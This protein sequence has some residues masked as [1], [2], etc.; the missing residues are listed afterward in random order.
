[1]MEFALHYRGVGVEVRRQGRS[2]SL[3]SIKKA[4]RKTSKGIYCLP[5]SCSHNRVSR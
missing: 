4:L 1:M 2:N 5:H 3:H